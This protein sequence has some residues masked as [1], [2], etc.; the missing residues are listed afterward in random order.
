M[1]VFQLLKCT[2]GSCKK[3]ARKMVHAG[4]W[5]PGSFESDIFYSL[6]HSSQA[7]GLPLIIR[8]FVASMKFAGTHI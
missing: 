6:P 7:V 5:F 2:C 3:A 8:V 4:D 1:K